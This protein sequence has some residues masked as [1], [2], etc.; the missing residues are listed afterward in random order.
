VMDRCEDLL[1]R[2]L[3]F[4]KGVV[5]ASDLP[6]NISRQRLQ[7]DRHISQMRKWLT[8]KVLDAL[9]D[10]RE[11]ETDKY[12]KFWGEFGRAMKEGVATDYDN[13]EKLLPLL[14]F[15]SSHHAS[16][17]TTL[18]AYLERMKP[19]QKDILYLTGESRKAI[20]NSPHLEAVR[21]KEYEVLF[22]SDPVDEFLLQHLFEFEGKPLKSLNKGTVTLGTE[23]EERQ[24]AE[25]LKEKEESYAAFMAACQKKLDEYIKQIRLSTRLVGSPACLVTE[26]HEFSPN[27]E[28]LLQ[29]TKG[30]GPKQK[31][32]MEL[33]P[34]H[35]LV[36]RLYERY[37]TNPDDSSVGDSMELLFHLA[38]LAE[39]SEIA[40]PV[41]LNQLT[42]DLLQK[43][44]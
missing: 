17:L 37:K 19:G 15:E 4:I 22:M 35:P 8:R 36:T 20:E 1:P 2:Y 41:R 6:L 5:D 9:A 33:N 25:Q 31:R 42:L 24:R 16:D 29:K 21:Q 13:N 39:G 30:G 27:L 18:K 43:A 23:E 38:L 40:D 10:M 11:K 3:R 14:M 44:G 34:D 12:L 28:R 32:I 7:Q 26:E